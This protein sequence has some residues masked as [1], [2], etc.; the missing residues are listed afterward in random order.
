MANTYSFDNNI[1][2]WKSPKGAIIRLIKD[3]VFLKDPQ[4]MIENRVKIFLKNNFKDTGNVLLSNDDLHY[5]FNPEIEDD[6]FKTLLNTE[7]A[8]KVNGLLYRYVSQSSFRRIIEDGTITMSSLICM[9]DE[10]EQ[11]YAND[12][13]KSRK[14][15][16]GYISVDNNS[17]DCYISSLSESNDDLMMWNM[18]GGNAKGAQLVFEVGAIDSD[19]TLS[20]VAYA[21]AKNYILE[22]NYVTKLLRKSCHGK[23]LQLR[24]WNIWQHFFKPYYYN[25]EHEVRL[26]YHLSPKDFNKREWHVSNGGLNFPIIKYRLFDNWN[27]DSVNYKKLPRFPLKLSRIVLGPLFPDPTVN[28]FALKGRLFDSAGVSAI[29][30]SCSSI[31]GYREI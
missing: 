21:N 31:K 17:L 27:E 24:R 18:Y 19:Y 25:G 15:R 29:G 11:D 6:L 13:V 10:T 20:N 26:L 4:R 16:E 5:W 3:E 2:F 7:K 1:H 8:K 22:L 28:A 12:Y 30:I 14:L 9:N 23:Y